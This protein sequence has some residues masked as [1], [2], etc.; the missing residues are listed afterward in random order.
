[1]IVNKKSIYYQRL[2]TDLFLLNI[3][4]LAAAI[5]AQP[6][7]VLIDRN[8]MFILLLALNILWF[9]YAAITEFYDELYLRSIA[10]QLLNI[11]KSMVI[12]IGTAVLFIFLVKEDLFTRNFIVFFGVLLF[13]TISLRTVVY[14]KIL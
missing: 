2:I 14:R 9:F 13:L 1:M 8:Y 6:Y 10:T 5:L 3:S 11:A 4:F 12:Q 7:H